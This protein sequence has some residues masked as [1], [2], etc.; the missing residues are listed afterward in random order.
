[1]AKI[2][3]FGGN[4]RPI[5]ADSLTGER[6]VFG[7]TSTVSNELT[8]QYNAAM[9]RGWGSV[10]ASDFPPLEWFNAQAFTAT[11][12]ISYL[13][14]MGLA[15]WNATQ[16]YQ[17]GSV[18][19]YAG[20]TYTCRTVDHVSATNPSLDSV[21]WAPPAT[22]ANLLINGD[23]YWRQRGALN[24]NFGCDRT[25]ISNA[26]ATEAQVRLST[27]ESILTGS[28]F[29]QEITQVSVTDYHEQRIENPQKYLGRQTFYSQFI[30]A[31]SNTT[32]KVEEIWYVNG[33][34]T[35]VDRGTIAVTTSFTS[36]GGAIL[37]SDSVTGFGVSAND[38]VAI[39]FSNY[40]SVKVTITSEQL[41]LGSVQTDFKTQGSNE[42]AELDLCQRYFETPGSTITEVVSGTSG[43]GGS[44]VFRNEFSYLVEKRDTGT[45]T[46]SSA[47]LTPNRVTSLDS[48]AG[49]IS[50]NQAATPV[51]KTRGFQMRAAIGTGAGYKFFWSVSAEL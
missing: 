8:A 35:V 40:G 2:N 48:F 6:F 10:G 30:K 17:I 51:L 26:S 14:Q 5:A 22:G 11:Q 12:F 16:E 45:L 3:R 29:A 15:E 27:A 44:S 38:Y 31:A 25:F 49:T 24:S 1:M 21:N 46:F 13:H 34:T 42:G 41:E 39:R 4:V 19:P 47:N 43:S 20:I 37:L 50:D 33:S 23:K 36:L 32:V 28:V 9:L 7:T 18:V